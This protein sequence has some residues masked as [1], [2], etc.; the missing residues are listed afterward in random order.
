MS[1]KDVQ[2]LI[3]QR[4]D[5]VIRVLAPTLTSTVFVPTNDTFFDIVIEIWKY[6][7]KDFRTTLP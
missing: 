4:M 3:K 7:L 1:R 6:G 2:E 5:Y